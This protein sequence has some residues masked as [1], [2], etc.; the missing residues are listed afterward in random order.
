MDQ[1]PQGPV[2]G[3]E[4]VKIFDA[5]ANLAGVFAR[6]RPASNP[7]QARDP[8]GEELESPLPLRERKGPQSE[9]R[10]PAAARRELHIASSEKLCEPAVGAAQIQDQYTRIVLDGL[11]QQKVQSKAFARAGRAED[12]RVSHVAFK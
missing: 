6:E 5:G 9:T 2:P 3:G 11:N 1:C 12:Q 10:A 8:A 4:G 7:Q